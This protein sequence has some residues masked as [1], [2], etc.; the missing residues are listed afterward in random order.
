MLNRV[1][2]H[3]AF[4]GTVLKLGAL[5]RVPQDIRCVPH[6]NYVFC[7]VCFLSQKLKCQNKKYI[8]NRDWH[9]K[10][11]LRSRHV[12]AVKITN[13]RSV[14]RGFSTD[15]DCGWCKGCGPHQVLEHQ[16]RK[17]SSAHGKTRYLLS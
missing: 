8:K 17:W 12:L 6:F 11:H 1:T 4:C 15:D 9:L 16:R 3:P 13:R 10:M 7:F 14:E 2:T 5:S